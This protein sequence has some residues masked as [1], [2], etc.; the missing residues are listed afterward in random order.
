M[1]SDH[2][3]SRVAESEVKDSLRHN[4]PRLL[5]AREKLLNHLPLVLQ[6]SGVSVSIVQQ[7]ITRYFT[8]QVGSLASKNNVLNPLF[9]ISFDMIHT[10]RSA[11]TADF[12]SKSSCSHC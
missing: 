6:A 11:V 10:G 4:L 12:L 8:F 5:G 2:C 3:M 1:P 9:N 7:E